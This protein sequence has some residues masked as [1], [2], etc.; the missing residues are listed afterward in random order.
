MSRKPQVLV[1]PRRHRTSFPVSANC[2]TLKVYGSTLPNRYNRIG[3]SER[4]S[5]AATLH[6]QQSPFM[7]YLDLT[8]PTA[9]ENLALDEALLEEAEASAAPAETLR[10]WESP[11]P[12]VVV[13]RSS[14]IDVE[15][16]AEACRAVGI[17]I[18]RRA[19]G[20]AAVVAGPGCLMYALVLSY[21][22]RPH[23]RALS[24]AHQC[25]LG[26]IAAALEPLAPGVQ[27]CGTSDLAI[28]QRKFS[29]NSARCRR[30][31][32]LYHGTLLY[33]F[34]LE[35]IDRCLAMPPRMPDYRAGRPHGG[36]VMNLPLG[37]EAIRQALREAW[38][39]RQP[40]GDWPTQRTAQLV[41]EKYGRPEWNELGVRA[42]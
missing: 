35:L 1:P 26:A 8:L 34:P 10:L 19:S 29:G 37:A 28:G 3:S 22:Q 39:A 13:G 14:R 17:P 5:S 15:V 32:L 16:R 6:R 41:A 24:Q 30:E 31:H 2:V 38:D 33:D 21:R 7:Q 18:L 36:F 9:A 20:G 42:V 27:R 25:V 23:L 40:C 4:S 12:L 11:Q